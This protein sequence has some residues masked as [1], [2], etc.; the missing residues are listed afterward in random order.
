VCP[1]QRRR[2]GEPGKLSLALT[3]LEKEAYAY[4]RRGEP[5]KHSEFLGTWQD[6][7][8]YTRGFLPA[9]GGPG[10]QNPNL[11]LAFS[12]LESVERRVNLEI[13]GDKLQATGQML[14]SLVAAICKAR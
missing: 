5:F 2:P 3:L 12:V 7:E 8:R 13:E 4:R 11:L 10:A 6:F 14:A 9:P 1:R